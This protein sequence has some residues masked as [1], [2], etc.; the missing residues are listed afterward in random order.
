[1]PTP[2][3]PQTSTEPMYPAVEGFIERAS[4]EEIAGL[5][6]SIKAGLGDLKGPKADQSKKVKAALDRTEELLTHLLEV[7]EKL[8]SEKH[9]S[10]GRK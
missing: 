3:Q 10:K 7:R 1:M 6:Q 5:F 4:P 2:S 8:T 9:A